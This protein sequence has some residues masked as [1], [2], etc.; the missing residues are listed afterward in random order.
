VSRRAKRQSVNTARTGSTT[1]KAVST[2]CR[3]CGRALNTHMNA[4]YFSFRATNMPEV[5]RILCAVAHAGKRYTNT[6]DWRGYSHATTP[7][8]V[9][10]IQL[11]ADIA[12]QALL[13]AQV[14]VKQLRKEVAQLK[15]QLA[16]KED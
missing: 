13:D 5:D 1:R 2:M 3:W 11:A 4:Y 6:G 15:K 14:K 16:S 9:E 8:L 12:G 7:D 10:P